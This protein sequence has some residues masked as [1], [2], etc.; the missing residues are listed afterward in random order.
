MRGTVTDVA[1]RFAAL[2]S[3]AFVAVGCASVV[4]PDEDMRGWTRDLGGSSADRAVPALDLSTAD[5]LASPPPDLAVAGDLRAPSDLA[6]ASDLAP[7]PPDLTPPAC[8]QADDGGAAAN[9]L[10]AAIGPSKRLLAATFTPARGWSAWLENTTVAVAAVGAGLPGA[11]TAGIVAARLTDNKLRTAV[12]DTCSQTLNAPAAPFTDALAKMGP[13]ALADM[14]GVDIAFTGSLGAGTDK[15]YVTRWDGTTFSGPVEHPYLTVQPLAV[16]RAGSSL[17]L[18]HTGV[19]GGNPSGAMY[20]GP[21]GATQ[22]LV[23]PNATTPSPPAATVTS[24]GTTVVVFRGNDTNLYWSG[25]TSGANAYGNPAQLC[26]GQTSCLID[27]NQPPRA[28]TG[29]DGKAVAVWVGKDGKLYSST[30]T[31]AQWGA[32]VEVSGGETASFLP[33]VAPGVGGATVELV[34]VRASDKALRHARLSGGAWSVTATLAGQ[35]LE[36]DP[37][38]AAAPTR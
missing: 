16:A 10:V 6:T 31:G 17:R 20:D 19:S 18:V 12:V 23:L 15:I 14:T 35:T 38:L 4:M 34:Y 26:A 21:A 33:A 2:A 5:D 3:A 37:A 36:G 29:S 7:P 1:L 13:A 25:R 27:S 8:P 28:V 11:R 24:D 22:A 32:A 30:L 9:L